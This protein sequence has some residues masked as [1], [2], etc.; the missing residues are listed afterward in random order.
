MRK[1]TLFELAIAQLLV[2]CPP[3]FAVL[4]ATPE[5]ATVRSLV[6]SRAA[7]QSIRRTATRDVFLVPRRQEDSAPL[8]VEPQENMRSF[9]VIG[10][11]C[12]GAE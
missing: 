9:G 5:L 6:R 11:C 1:L 10:S 2:R 7:L 4:P 8:S 3:A 12:L